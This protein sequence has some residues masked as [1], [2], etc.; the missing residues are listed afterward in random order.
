MERKSIKSMGKNTSTKK[1]D[2]LRLREESEYN[3]H[4]SSNEREISTEP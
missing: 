3:E 2:N 1:M 4:P